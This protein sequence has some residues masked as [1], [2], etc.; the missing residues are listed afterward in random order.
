[1]EDDARLLLLSPEGPADCV[2]A[3]LLPA[4]TVQ[5]ETELSVF[6]WNM[7]KE[8]KTHPDSIKW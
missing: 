8:Y 5:H 4:G 3:E 6:N 1:M 7:Y 2:L